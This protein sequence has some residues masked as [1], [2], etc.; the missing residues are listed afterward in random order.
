MTSTAASKGHHQSAVT[1]DRVRSVISKPPDR[2][3][4]FEINSILPWFRNMKDT[5]VLGQLK[6]CEYYTHRFINNNNNTNND[7][8]IESPDESLTTERAYRI[9]ITLFRHIDITRG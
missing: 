7:S 9:Y 3:K 5:K 2:R 4:D 6:P 1:Y 8:L